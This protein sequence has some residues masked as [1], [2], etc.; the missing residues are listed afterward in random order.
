M[1]V[2]VSAAFVFAG[3]VDIVSPFT[4]VSLTMVVPLKGTVLSTNLTGGG[5]FVTV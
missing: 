4:F 3:G 1:L 2:A 5:I